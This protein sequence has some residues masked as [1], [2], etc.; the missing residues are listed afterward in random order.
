MFQ[1][2]LDVFAHSTHLP[3]APQKKPLRLSLKWYRDLED[4]KGWCFYYILNSHYDIRFTD[5]NTCDLFLRGFLFDDKELIE[6]TKLRMMFMGENA[7]IDFNLYDF[8][9]GFDDLN[10]HDRYLRVPLYY[11]SLW[12][13]FKLAMSPNSPFQIDESIQRAFYAL[14]PDKSPDCPYSESAHHGSITLNASFS[15]NYPHLHALASNQSDPTKRA[16]ASFVASNPKAPVRNAF[17]QLL[18]AYRPI[19]GGGGGFKPLWGPGAQ[20]T[21]FL[22]QVS[23]NPRLWYFWGIGQPD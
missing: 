23:F 7:R 21:G 19:G 6:C 1:P 12:M 4:F 11:P 3:Q 13:F 2:L 16:F 8:G 20:K 14:A 10:F 18:N 15:G 5:K 22:S 17:H 9:M